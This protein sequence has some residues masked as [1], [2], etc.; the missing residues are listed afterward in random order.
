[1]QVLFTF[2]IFFIFSLY[3]YGG[4]IYEPYYP[5][6][7]NQFQKIFHTVCTE[8]I[9]CIQGT[10]LHFV[11]VAAFLGNTWII[12][13]FLSGQSPIVALFCPVNESVW[14]H[15][16]LLY[17]PF[18]FVSI[19]EYLSLHPVVLPFFY[20]RYLGVL[21][22]MFFTVSVFYT[23]S[24]ILGRNFLILDI[25]LFLFQCNIFIWNVWIYFR[26]DPFSSRDRTWLCSLTL[27]DNIFFLL[28]IY[29]FSARSSVILF[30][31]STT[32]IN[33]FPYIYN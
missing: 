21:L 15:L 1:M 17:F 2:F 16:K 8:I 22:G 14:E 24:G 31:I 5:L 20:C 29:M 12:S 25:L 26:Q 13:L 18:L 3:W 11:L 7:Y 33:T 19:W 9:S 10:A 27:V 28:C 30:N 23:Y 6:C 32:T 4:W